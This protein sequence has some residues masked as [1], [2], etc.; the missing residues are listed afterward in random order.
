MYLGKMP[1]RNGLGTSLGGEHQMDVV[2]G[3]CLGHVWL[4]YA[5][6]TG[7]MKRIW[8]LKDR[9]KPLSYIICPLQGQTDEIM[10]PFGHMRCL[11]L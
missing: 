10:H 6:P 5:P 4:N 2:F 7:A 11:P 8:R 9:G 3:Q 1:F